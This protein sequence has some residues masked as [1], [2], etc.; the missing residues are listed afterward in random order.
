MEEPKAR[1]ARRSISA[2]LSDTRE[3]SGLCEEETRELSAN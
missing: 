3:V 1:N 2:A